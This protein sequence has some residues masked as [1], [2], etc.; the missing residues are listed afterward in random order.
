MK[1]VQSAADLEASQHPDDGQ[2]EPGSSDALHSWV[3]GGVHVA[4]INPRRRLGKHVELK[5]RLAD[6]TQMTSSSEPLRA[7]VSALGRQRLSHAL[8]RLSGKEGEVVRL[9][10]VEGRT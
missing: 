6:D 9:A 2:A 8:G 3:I 1:L 4:G 5:Q 7:L 10:Y